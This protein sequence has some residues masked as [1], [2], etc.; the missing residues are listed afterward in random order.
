LA[1][2]RRFVT[3]YRQSLQLCFAVE[4]VLTANDDKAACNLHSYC[5]V[6]QVWLRSFLC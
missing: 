3:V 6:A 4:V 2:A 5:D 1:S